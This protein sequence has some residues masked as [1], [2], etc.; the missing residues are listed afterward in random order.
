[1]MM[2]AP[3]RILRRAAVLLISVALSVANFAAAERRRW[4]AAHHACSEA[5]DGG[6]VLG[7]PC[8]PPTFPSDVDKCNYDPF[9]NASY[10]PEPR[11]VTCAAMAPS[12]VWRRDAR[13]LRREIWQLQLPFAPLRR[14]L[15]GE[16]EPSNV[17]AGAGAGAGPGF[18]CTRPTS[19]SGRWK[20][21]KLMEHGTCYNLY[22]FANVVG[23]LWAS[24]IPVLVGESRYRFGPSLD[25]TLRRRGQ[26]GAGAGASAGTKTTRYEIASTR[27]E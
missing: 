17:G 8:P 11:Y 13:A 3:A 21:V 18:E 26:G 19:R 2:T 15:K 10:L 9:L 7:R 14:A 23:A 6:G 27:V 20:L 24:G 5:A 22:A 1:M 4:D 16:G 12:E 25:E